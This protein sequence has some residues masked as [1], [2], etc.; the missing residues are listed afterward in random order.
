MRLL[1]KLANSKSYVVFQPEW[2]DCRIRPGSPRV[3]GIRGIDP[4]PTDSPGECA[5]T[6]T[7]TFW[8]GNREI[9]ALMEDTIVPTNQSN[10]QLFDSKL[11]PFFL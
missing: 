6:A 9:L 10:L 4:N 11:S 7:A 1:A 2:K 3:L 5:L 8:A